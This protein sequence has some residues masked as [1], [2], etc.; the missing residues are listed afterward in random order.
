MIAN[1]ERLVEVGKNG[2]E[3]RCVERRKERNVLEKER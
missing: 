1:R 2:S 3:K